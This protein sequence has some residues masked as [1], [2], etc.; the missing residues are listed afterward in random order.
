MPIRLHPTIAADDPDPA[1]PGSFLRKLPESWR[2]K[3]A[4]IDGEHQSMID[5]LNA[6]WTVFG[7]DASVPFTR[8]APAFAALKRDMRHHFAHEEAEMASLSYPGLAEHKAQ[9]R[10]VML[11]LEKI[12]AD[13]VARGVVNRDVMYALLDA[14]ID[15]VLRADLPFK[16][17]L[18][19]RGLIE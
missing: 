17:F 15:D 4:P 18:F 1:R 9:H 16:T 3:F 6:G 14:L 8:F 11:K 19:D 7:P 2:L 13:A 5:D 10:T 12:E